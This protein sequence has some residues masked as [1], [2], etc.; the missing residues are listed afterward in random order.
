[1]DGMTAA[2][3]RIWQLIAGLGAWIR[4]DM[5]P[6]Q[7]EDA[8]PQSHHVAANCGERTRAHD[9]EIWG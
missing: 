9:L 7:S 4:P 2:L 1:M 3:F 6:G 8:S 5:R